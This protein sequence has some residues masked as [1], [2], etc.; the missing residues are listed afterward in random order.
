[1]IRL[2]TLDF[3]KSIFDALSR[4]RLVIFA[5]AGVSVG[6]PSN[7][8]GFWALAE[9]IAHGT[10]KTPCKPLDGFLGELSHE[11]VSVHER[12]REYLSPP[13]SA[14]NALHRDLIKLFGSPDRVKIITTNYDLHFETAAEAIFTERPP[15]FAAPALPV[16]SDFSGIVHVHGALPDTRNLIMTDADFGRAYLAEGWAKRFLLE[17]FSHY[18]VLFIGYSHDDVVMNY[19]AR[20][21]P[22]GRA[23]RRYAL[24]DKSGSWNLLG[25]TPINFQIDP[26]ANAFKELY[27]GVERL[28]ERATRS[29]LVWRE[30]LEEICRVQPPVDEQ[31]IGELEHALS[32]VYTVRIFTSFAKGIEWIE[33]LDQ[34]QHLDELFQTDS[35][36]KKAECLSA[37]LAQHAAEHAEKLFEILAGHQLK[38]N[39][40]LWWQIGREIGV[41]K[42]VSISHKSLQ[43]WVAILI[44][45][46]PADVQRDVPMWVAERCGELGYFDLATKLFIFMAKHR[47]VATRGQRL[48]S[49]SHSARGYEVRCELVAD[50]WSLNEV[51]ENYLKPN[52]ALIAEMLLSGAV[53]CLED[54]HEDLTA[55]NQSTPHWDAFSY[56]RSAIES[57]GQDRN[58]DAIDVLIDSVRDSL[59]WMC[60]N[61]RIFADAWIERSVSSDVPLLRRIAVHASTIA[62]T[63]SA[64]QQ[65]H[66]LISRI[67]LQDHI[68]H[69]EIFQAIKVLYP[70][71]TGEARELL[72]D[73]VSKFQMEEIN[74][75][76][77]EKCTARSKFDFLA[78]LV[79]ADPSCVQAMKAIEPIKAQYPEWSHGMHPDLKH[80]LGEEI[81][82]AHQSSWSPERL[83]SLNLN[84]KLDELLS[85]IESSEEAY[86][87]NY[88][89]VTAVTQTCKTHPNWGLRLLQAL[90]VRERFD[91]NLWPAVLKGMSEN[92]LSVPQWQQLLEVIANPQLMKFHVKPLAEMLLSLSMKAEDQIY[93]EV[94]DLADSLSLDIWSSVETSLELVRSDDWALQCLIE[95]SAMIF[96]FWIFTLSTK[97][98]ILKKTA[99]ELPDLY[100]RWFESGLEDSGARGAYARCL[101]AG[102]FAFLLSLDRDWALTHVLPLFTS[103]NDQQFS[104]AWHGFLNWGKINANVC[105]VLQAA[106]PLVFSRIDECLPN[107]R[108]RF[109]EM[110]TY[111]LIKSDADPIPDAFPQLFRHGTQ[112]DRLL[113]ASHLRYQ[114]RNMPA[115]ERSQLWR[116]WLARYWQGR[117]HAIPSALTEKEVQQMLGWL[118][119]L[120]AQYSEGVGF[121]V[122][123]PVSPLRSMTSLFELSR[124]DLVAEYPAATAK[125]LVFLCR[126]FDSMYSRDIGKIAK[127][128]TNL[129]ADLANELDEALAR[130]GVTW[131]KAS[132]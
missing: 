62:S 37:W 40:D 92:I 100:K 109:V 23:G 127:R 60:L 122:Q 85:P 32:E 58:P 101:L 119:W 3:D 66:W 34:Q 71:A 64:D 19:L 48:F 91:S 57:D 5:G 15:V 42:G 95:P 24:T 53:R 33:W 35:L 69:H 82:P 118:P 86:A 126:V 28:A 81:M 117:L 102:H 96:N 80:W 43:R 11:G 74:D 46:A 51:W 108:N 38:L 106:F 47:I 88:G 128:L 68:A 98:K 130:A 21:L 9:Q 56:S 110:F 2:A 36:S 132:G 77:A 72:L 78:R 123:S 105:T 129:P 75:W 54:M 99:R 55:W 111:F 93:L 45:S 25:I 14:P 94:C 49:R 112:G 41:E 31:I 65:L 63:K 67:G 125:L 59:Q 26:G 116:R 121:M 70:N 79:I 131:E 83:L 52:L 22:S 8:A 113:F 90:G 97:S 27:D 1:M 12:A 6:A 87:E 13:G 10:G 50:H 17:V 107:H 84:E 44:Y 76:S 7:L 61:R 29:A 4:D 124:S 39:A 73:A 18:T 16:G 30:R 120:G 114:L 20:A 115:E 89:L 103:E 104:L